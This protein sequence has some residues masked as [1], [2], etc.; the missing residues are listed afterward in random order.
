MTL[1]SIS[2]FWNI[3][4]ENYGDAFHVST[5]IQKVVLKQVFLQVNNAE[6]VKCKPRYLPNARLAILDQ[7]S[8]ATGED[9]LLKMKWKEQ[10]NKFYQYKMVQ[11]KNAEDAAFMENMTTHFSNC[12]VRNPTCIQLQT[13]Q[14]GLQELYASDPSEVRRFFD[15]LGLKGFISSNIKVAFLVC[16]NLCN[17]G[18]VNKILEL[19][20]Q[21]TMQQDSTMQVTEDATEYTPEEIRKHWKQS[22]HWWVNVKWKG[23]PYNET[24]Q[25]S[26][27]GDIR[28]CELFHSY[29]MEHRVL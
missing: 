20:N 17:Q 28:N 10:L 13:T 7:P 25:Q 21:Q 22:Q 5:K 29:V 4:K 6:F 3:L 9:K 15:L 14:L 26:M 23:F 11:N 12:A 24:D 27:E 16:Q 1:V 2:R 8:D 18:M 19:I